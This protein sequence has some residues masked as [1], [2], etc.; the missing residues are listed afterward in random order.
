MKKIR[1][2]DEK[3]AYKYLQSLGYTNIQYEPDSNMPPDFLINDTIAIEVRRLNLSD[4]ESLDE[5]IPLDIELKKHI[6]IYSDEKTLKV[7]PFRNK[8]K[9]WWLVLV[10]H[11]DY[12]D[13]KGDEYD[14][15]HFWDKLL[16]I[17][18]K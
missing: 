4:N 12:R 11:I 17:E 7:A 3:I 5:K 18:P 1:N 2:D 15:K 14:I 9:E 13:L 8:Y 16:I 10:N 6:Q